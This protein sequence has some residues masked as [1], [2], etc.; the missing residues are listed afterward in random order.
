MNI[1]PAPRY[2]ELQVAMSFS[3]L[4][5]ASHPDE[6]ATTA[7]AL[8]LEALAVT[9]RNS[10]AGVVRAHMAAKEAGIRLVVGCRLDCILDAAPSAVVPI[11]KH[12]LNSRMLR[13]IG[14]DAVK[15][16]REGSDYQ[17]IE[18]KDAHAGL[19]LLAF[20][21]DR[22][23]YADLCR[24]LTV[25]RRRAP[26]GECYID[27]DDVEAHSDNMIFVVLPPAILTDDF[28]IELERLGRIWQGRC[29]LA[30][31][32]LLLGDDQTRLDQLAQ[33]AQACR[34]P[35]LATNDVHFHE[36]ARKPL[37]DLLTCVRHGC[38]IDQAGY[39]L[40]PNAERCLKSPHQ[41]AQ[42]FA[43][44]PG[45]LRASVEIAERCQFSLDELRYEYP[46]ELGGESGDTQTEL[47]RLAW[48]GA[49]ERYGVSEADA[50]PERMRKQV[51]HEL[52]LIG[53]L[54]YAPY[55]LTVYDIVRF[56]RSRGI[57]CQ[58]RGSAA[59]SSVCYCLGITSVDPARIDLLFERF[60]S[61]DRNE[62]PDIDV[63]FEHE[64]REEVMQYIYQKYGRHRAGLTATVICYR[65]RGAVRDVGKALGLSEDVIAAVSS[66]I[67]GWNGKGM[68][69][70]RVAELG[71]DVDAPRL[72]Q[73]LDFTNQLRGFPRHLSQHVGGFVLTDGP[74]HEL[75]PIENAS[76]ADRTVIEWDKDDLDALGILKVDVLA[77]G[78]LSCMRRCFDLID[79]HYGARLDLASLPAEDPQVYDMLCRADSVGVFQV[80][81]R[82]QM[83]MLPRL[84]PRTFY[85][86]V[87]EVAIVRPG[88]IQGDM[89]HPYLRRRAGEEQINY[90]SEELREVL[91]KTMG[92]PLFQEQAMKIAI[93][94]AGFTPGEADKLRRAM[95]TFKKSGQIALFGDKM[96]NGMI[97]RGYDPQFAER[98]FKQIEGFGTYGFPESHAASFALLVY[99]SS[100]MKRH[101]PEVF[102][103]ALLNSQPMGFYAPAQIVRDA[104]DHGVEILPVD[105][106]QSDWDSTLE[107]ASGRVI[108]P[109]SRFAS[110]YHPRPK[111]L[112]LG[113][114][115]VKGLAENDAAKILAAR[116][117]GY[118]DLLTLWRRSGVKPQALEAI[119]RAD[120]YGSM[121]LQ[122]REAFWAIRALPDDPLPLFA[123]VG[124]EEWKSVETGKERLPQ[125][126]LG[127]Q[128]ADD[129]RAL[130]LSLKAHPMK[131]VREVLAA[132]GTLDNG[133]GGRVRVG[134]VQRTA[135][136]LWECRDGDWVRLT[137]VVLV[138]QRPG[139]ASGVIFISLED[140]T[141]VANLVVWPSVFE[142]FRRQVLGASLIQ[143]DG[144]V[145]KVGSGEHQV[146]HVV[147]NRLVDRTQLLA[148]MQAENGVEDAQIL[149]GE[150][151][152]TVL[153]HADEVARPV[154]DERVDP[155]LPMRDESPHR[156]L[157]EP[158]AAES[159]GAKAESYQ[160]PRPQR[161]THP[162]NANIQFPIRRATG[163]AHV[164]GKGDV[165]RLTPLVQS[166]S[167]PLVPE[168]RTSSNTP[169]GA[170]ERSVP[171][172][173]ASTSGKA[174][175]QTEGSRRNKAPKVGQPEPWTGPKGTRGRM[176]G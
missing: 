48:S 134:Q 52:E 161:A 76:M 57:L 166:Q 89:V 4:R 112:R 165:S 28:A 131:L 88:P 154:P 35:M 54:N 16:G 68:E 107:F 120:G 53:Q 9:D 29:F 176:F 79:Q 62:P 174:S 156:V 121:E 65:T 150:G 93:V 49:C 124:H 44:Y 60:I 98:C 27:L 153:A 78:M 175:K 58:G 20:P 23:G 96:R 2:A 18:P 172:K 103:C 97:A 136:D 30:A 91:G 45:A 32:H 115:Q 139:S 85:D 34:A 143:V 117:N 83:N 113:L 46:R 101:Y 138:R 170:Y 116:G 50:L 39:R 73:A 82:A 42:L 135:S 47:E 129:Y 5:G 118:P 94:A 14:E 142:Q 41:M 51:V 152:K 123:A 114:R 26:K 130:R 140:E 74:L 141:G 108:N 173:G 159:A 6:L 102:A 43:R 22:S 111:A 106:N 110:S 67:S 163:N 56:A 157:G 40:F 128:V 119:A 169:A 146:I 145:Q 80:E 137:G 133:R 59:N 37:Q 148:Q 21:L 100:W 171:R 86:L 71:L 24:L 31:Q 25:G 61:A 11:K 104:R 33:M 38:T 17:V 15:A 95:A 147:A 81:S 168:A 160:L 90:P 63:D 127:E 69:D 36:R 8:G 125:M 126:S 72:R 84:K 66:N 99:S 151:F 155:A 75:V 87:I 122:R 3:F 12:Q 55:F 167:Q 132:E 1:Q 149:P 10:L 70:E 144:R 64:R 13:N 164:G 19:S 162:R 77:L 158:K 92:V 7:A 109:A 105:V